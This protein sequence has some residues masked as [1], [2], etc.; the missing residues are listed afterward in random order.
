M[1]MFLSRIF[2]SW[3]WMKT[4]KKKRWLVKNIRSILQ[5]FVCVV[6]ENTYSVLNKHTIITYIYIYNIQRKK[7]TAKWRCV[8][9]AVFVLITSFSH[10]SRHSLHT[11]LEEIREINLHL[12]L[13]SRHKNF[14]IR[15]AFVHRSVWTTRH[16]WV[17]E[18]EREQ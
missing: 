14:N 6:I 10:L 18:R 16:K 5:K 2:Y 17:H 1:F 11:Y 13:L 8:I 3:W 9:A 12:F 4:L 15:P 7:G